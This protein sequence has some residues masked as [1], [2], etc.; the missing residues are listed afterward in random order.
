MNSA[1]LISGVPRVTRRL[2]V[3]LAVSLVLH[4]ALVSGVRFTAPRYV[5]PLPLEV[6]IRRDAAPEPDAEFPLERPSEL[7]AK[8][9][10][11]EPAQPPAPP[12]E[13]R[14]APDARDA[15]ARLGL[16]LDKYYTARELDVRAEPINEVHLVYP[17]RPY[18]MRTKGRV[19]LRIFINE[20]GAIDEVA[21]IEAVPPG[22]FEE[23]ALTATLALQF[24]P[25][26]KAG[27]NVKS[28]KTIEVVFDPYENINIP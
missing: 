16:P 10:A 5:A 19:T 21:V 13:L 7:T 6:E 12:E 22:I 1:T 17:E 9:A 8:P 27:R 18:A 2:I 20:R 25:A 24:K 28:Q 26:M 14:A 15:P 23:A 3:G 4:I 11:A